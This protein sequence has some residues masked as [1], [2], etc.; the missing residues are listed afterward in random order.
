MESPP[1]RTQRMRTALDTHGTRTNPTLAIT[2]A[3]RKPRSG[4]RMR[5]TIQSAM[6][7]GIAKIP[8]AIIASCGASR[9]VSI[10]SVPVFSPVLSYS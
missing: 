2:S 8:A 6:R 1:V 7:T 4:W 10:L 5:L 3:C 9:L